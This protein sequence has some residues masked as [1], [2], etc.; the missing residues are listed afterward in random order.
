LQPIEDTVGE[1]YVY[2]S[3]ITELFATNPYVIRIHE[4]TGNVC[5]LGNSVYHI[6]VLFKD[7]GISLHK[8]LY[9]F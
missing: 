7:N 9:N 1:Q 6:P 3:F 5:Q 2:N 8:I 4:D